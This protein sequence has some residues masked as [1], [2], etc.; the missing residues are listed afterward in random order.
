M[1]KLNMSYKKQA[2]VILGVI[3]P[4]VLLAY[5]LAENYRLKRDLVKNT[6]FLSDLNN[7]L[8]SLDA[9]EEKNSETLRRLILTSESKQ[10]QLTDTVTKTTPSVVSIVISREVPQLEVSYVNPFGDDPFFRNF[11]VQVP[12]YTQKG[13]EKKEVGAGSGFIVSSNGYILTNKHVVYDDAA[14]Y[15]VLLSNGKQKSA[16]VVYRDPN[17]DVAVIKIEGSVYR[18]LPLGNS[19]ILKVGETVVAIGNA[20]GEF[21]NS[22]SVGVVSGIGRTIEAQNQATG[23]VEELKNI[24]QTDAAINPGNSGGPLLNLSGEVVGINVAT[25]SGSNSIGFS[26]PI[27]TLKSVIGK[28]LK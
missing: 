3:I 12:V 17:N 4:A 14:E 26:I 24:I 22:V 25:A 19:D 8:K 5:L 27:N 6:V 21:S 10:N 9:S 15:T 7:Q 16:T 11:G 20:L 1:I 28:Y 23:A 13:I 2:A 18:P